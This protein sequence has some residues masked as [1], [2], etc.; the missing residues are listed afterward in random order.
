MRSTLVMLLF[1]GL[2]L[3][4]MGVSSCEQKLAEQSGIKTIP[5][6]NNPGHVI[7]VEVDGG[8][9]IGKVLSTAQGTAGGIPIVGQVLMGVSMLAQLMHQVLLKRAKT[10]AQD[11]NE[12]YDRSHAATNAGLQS[13]VDSQPAVVGHA[14]VAEIDHAHDAADVLAEHQDAIQPVT[15]VAA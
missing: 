5:D 10:A 15:K 14:L 4:M 13:F 1:I 12:E 6:P 3:A 11:L 2:A 7:V 9:N 8:G